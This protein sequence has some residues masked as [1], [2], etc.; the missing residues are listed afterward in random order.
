MNPS[1]LSTSNPYLI[2]VLEF[3]TEAH[4]GQCRKNTNLPYITHPIAVAN[5]IIDCYSWDLAAAVALLHDVVE[6][7]HITL[8]NIR[9]ELHRI[10]YDEFFTNTI[11]LAVDLLTKKRENFAIIEYLKNIKNNEITRVVK[12]ADLEHNMSDLKPGNLLDKYRLCEEFLKD[13]R[14]IINP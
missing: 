11:I 4:R 8:E 6:D 14:V 10:G 2:K 12:L 13:E 9:E 3:A 1:H 5:I 7:T